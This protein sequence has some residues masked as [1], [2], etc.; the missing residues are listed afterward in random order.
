MTRGT[1]GY[2][3]DKRLQS[4]HILDLSANLPI[5]VEAIDKQERIEA[6]IPVVQ[7]MVN[8]GLVMLTDVDVI[9]YGKD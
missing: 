6:V 7:E 4:A 3:K 2:G 5:I 9:K 1:E 8:E